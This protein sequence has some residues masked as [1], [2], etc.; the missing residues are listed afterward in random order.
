MAR[1]IVIENPILN[2]P[3][4]EPARHFKFD[5]DGITNEIV[6]SR[7]ISGYFVPVPPPKK[8]TRQAALVDKWIWLE[9][10]PLRAKPAHESDAQD[11]KDAR[12]STACGMWVSAVNDQGGFGRWAFIEV[13]DPWNAQNDIRAALEELRLER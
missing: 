8:R 1:Q 9:R 11:D 10:E 12:V 7:R 13:R 6:E 5:T 4:E 3:F 2:S